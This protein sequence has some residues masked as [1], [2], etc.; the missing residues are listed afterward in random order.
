MQG[1]RDELSN[2]LLSAMLER[3]SQRLGNND[4]DL[5]SSRGRYNNRMQLLPKSLPLGP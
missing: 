1:R 3:E 2:V 4:I 5:P